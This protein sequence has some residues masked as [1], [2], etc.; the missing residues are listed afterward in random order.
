MID[1]DRIGLE[2]VCIRHDLPGNAP[3]LYHSGRG[4]RAVL[5]GGTTTLRE[6]EP[7]GAA[8]GTTLSPLG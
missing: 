2:P 3:R 4:Y 7:T 6:D 1:R 5:I 8:P